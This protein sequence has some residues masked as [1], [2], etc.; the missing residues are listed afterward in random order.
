MRIGLVIYGSLDT[1]SGGYLYDRTLVAKLRSVGD[2]VAIVSLTRRNYLRNLSD[3]FSS[4]LRR[5]LWGLEADV[6]LQ[7]ELNHPSLFRLNRSVREQI[8]CPVV[9]IVHLLKSSSNHAAWR[10]CWYRS[11]EQRYLSGV[12]GLIYNSETTRRDAERLL[13]QAQARKHSSLVAYP[14]SDRLNPQISDEELQNR[15]LD[16]PFRLLFLGN[17]IPRK[18]LH[19]ALKAL[20]RLPSDQ[21]TLTVV[22]N[23]HAHRSYARAVRRQINKAGLADNVLFT[24]VLS[25]RELSKIIKANH[26]L[27]MPSSYEGYGIVYAEAMGFGLPAIGTTSGA[28]AEII[29]HH[30]DGFLIP[31]GD[32]V[33][34][35]S[36]LTELARNR[37]R[38]LEMSLA[39]RN[40]FQSLPTWNTSMN[41]IRTFLVELVNNAVS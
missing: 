14:G 39:A 24:G 40:R 21:W 41:A 27:V 30:V 19:V 2:S 13:T 26:V 17:V 22:G 33:V 5:R 35:G 12:D 25:D 9:S 16:D 18:G 20:E 34:L 3:N 15:A 6:V 10:N 36:Y 32:S 28:A 7:D 8:R 37:Q 1:L 31:R 11:I 23:V 38:L 29:R 4:S